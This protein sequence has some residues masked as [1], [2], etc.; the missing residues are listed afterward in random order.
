MTEMDLYG[1]AIIALLIVGFCWLIDKVESRLLA[2]KVI[3]LRKK[4]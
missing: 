3:P 1:L 4:I 2:E